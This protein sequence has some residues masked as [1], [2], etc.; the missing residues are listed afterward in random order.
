MTK[1][2]DSAKRKASMNW[3]W[4]EGIEAFRSAPLPI[5]V[6]FWF[7]AILSVV[8]IY[9]MFSSKEMAMSYTNIAGPFA[10]YFTMFLAQAYGI[11][12]VGK[13]T[14]ARWYVGGLVVIQL[15]LY[16]ALNLVN[17]VNFI[18]LAAPW[19]PLQVILFI[20]VF[21]GPLYLP[22]VTSYFRLVD[23]KLERAKAEKLERYAQLRK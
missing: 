12:A 19:W 10:L 11:F 15:G 17:S 6:L 13:G 16:L 3:G 1:N 20:A 2:P 8:N 21:I 7:A 22:S 9:V 4:K 18:Y 23:E 5:R 14:R